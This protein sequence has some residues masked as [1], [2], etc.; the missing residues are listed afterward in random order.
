M[1]RR[2][3]DG[4]VK[5]FEGE[6]REG[7]RFGEGEG[8][9]HGR[10]SAVRE[11]SKF[12]WKSGVGKGGDY[13]RWGGFSGEGGGE[14]GVMGG[15]AA[16]HGRSGPSAGGGAATSPAPSRT[17]TRRAFTGCTSL[18]YRCSCS[19]WWSRTEIGRWALQHLQRGRGGVAG[20]GD[21]PSD[22]GRD[23]GSC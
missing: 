15:T 7:N 11:E 17:S 2:L 21:L 12:A 20:P 19:N 6:E 9:K 16:T 14:E 4:T 1:P 10:E 22:R 8:G 13:D 5:D 18:H 23:G 3:F